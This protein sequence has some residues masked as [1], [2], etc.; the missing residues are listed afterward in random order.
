MITNNDMVF[1]YINEVESRISN[2]DVAFKKA[3]HGY[4]K[5]RRDSYKWMLRNVW[6]LFMQLSENIG[7]DVIQSP[8][9]YSS[10][11][12][13]NGLFIEVREGSI[14]IINSAAY[15]AGN[16]GQGKIKSTSGARMP[17]KRMSQIIA[18]AFSVRRYSAKDREKAIYE[19]F[20]K[21]VKYDINQFL[22]T[23]LNI[24]MV[25]PE[26]ELEVNYEINFNWSKYLNKI[27]R[28]VALRKFKYGLG[29]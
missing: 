3:L 16:A 9:M 15:S 27:E 21:Y 13:S 26:E 23:Q 12:S 17:I 14:F 4:M 25:F 7:N 5:Q 19:Q 18:T 2:T 28:I 6:N 11:A 24:D 22:F 20:W 29:T 8:G 1:K 10:G